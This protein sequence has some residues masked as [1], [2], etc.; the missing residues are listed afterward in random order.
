[1]NASVFSLPVHPA[2]EVF[3]ML[4]PD[5]LAELAA[6]IKANGLAY[7][8]I[9]K[10]GVLIDGRNRREA[11]RVAGVVPTTSE[12]NGADPVAYILSTNINRRHMT[13]GQRAMAVAKIH[14]V[15][16]QG[17]G[18]NAEARKAAESAGFSP[19]LLAEARAVLHWAPELANAVLAGAES[20][21]HAYE[22]ATERKGQVEAPQK[23]LASLHASD[24]DL[25]DKVMEGLLSI[26][27]AESASHGRR[28]KARAQRQ[29]I[30]A[31]LK[32]VANW[33]FLFEGENLVCL[34]TIC[35]DYPDELS[36]AEVRALLTELRELLAH[37]LET[38]K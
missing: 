31:G 2:A 19:R 4:S 11:C 9:V 33:K 36:A 18:L 13:K 25:A 5:E 26:D 12:L 38:V 35:R 20:L 10:D 23:R 27:D 30:Y 37:A 1:M 7:P 6:D 21:D 24:S 29:G 16:K 22:V 17:R 15:G 3:P 8:L 28:E 32:A 14:P 34:A